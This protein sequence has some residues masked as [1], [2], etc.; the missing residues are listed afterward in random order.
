[1]SDEEVVHS[2]LRSQGIELRGKLIADVSVPT[3]FY[4]HVKMS[5]DSHGRRIPSFQKLKSV[6]EELAPKGITIEFFLFD[7]ASN[8]A[9]A[10]LRAT[11]LAK[12]SELIR[13][14]FATSASKGAKIWLEP[15]TTISP[16]NFELIKQSIEHFYVELKS[17]V[18]SVAALQDANVPGKL[19][20][21]AT[22]RKHA[23]VDP[24]TL[25]GALADKNFEIP[26]DDWLARKLDAFRKSGD[27]VQSHDRRYTLTMRVLKMLGTKKSRSS[28]DISRLLAV[29]K[30]SK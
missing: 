28:P 9:E 19:A 7:E 6:H 5:I 18:E 24:K 1:M 15:K 22:I 29:A 12:Y 21:L 14:V 8:N 26:S 4:V 13:N 10:S 2:A 16:E 11:L 23:P 30:W 27:V 25:K 3:L 17:T 20:I